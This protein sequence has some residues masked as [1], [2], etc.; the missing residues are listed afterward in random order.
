MAAA[1]DVRNRAEGRATGLHDPDLD[2]PLAPARPAASAPVG[3]EFYQRLVANP[4]LGFFGVLVW[5]AL[6]EAAFRAQRRD[7]IV[8]ALV[9][10]WLVRYLWQYHCLDCGRTGRLSRWREHACEGVNARRLAGRPRWWRG[11]TPGVQT[12]LWVVLAAALLA[13]WFLR[14]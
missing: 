13:A 9:S 4:F 12:A 6:L 5:F 3:V 8:G 1:R 14:P 11:P 7:L 2:V 10:L